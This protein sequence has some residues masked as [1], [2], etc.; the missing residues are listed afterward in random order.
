MV[1]EESGGGLGTGGSQGHGGLLARHRGRVREAPATVPEPRAVAIAQVHLAAGV[2][3][4]E[5][6]ALTPA[7][8]EEDGGFQFAA[9]IAVR[10]SLERRDQTRINDMQFFRIVGLFAQGSLV[11]GQ[12]EQQEAVFQMA[13]ILVQGVFRNAE[14]ERSQVAVELAH[15]ER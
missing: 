6:V 3:V 9:H 10:I 12:Q 8:V 4:V 7:Q 1:E 15:M 5:Q 2:R 11:F 13:Q 14:T